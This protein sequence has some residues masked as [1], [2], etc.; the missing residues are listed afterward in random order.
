MVFN[1]S[2]ER[3]RRSGVQDE[4]NHK[5]SEHMDEVNGMEEANCTGK[6]M[7]SS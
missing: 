2:V 3:M 7:L 5:D 1:E 4:V 6:A